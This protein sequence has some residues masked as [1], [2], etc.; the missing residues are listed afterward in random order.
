MS[1]TVA[2]LVLLAWALI[3]IVAGA[4]RIQTQDA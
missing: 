3:P 1:T 4:R 2:V